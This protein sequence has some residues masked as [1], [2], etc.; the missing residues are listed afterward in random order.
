M[1]SPS[2]RQ[3]KLQLITAQ[4]KKIE[5]DTKWLAENLSSWSSQ[6][7]QSIRAKTNERTKSVESDLPKL[8]QKA[9][10]SN[11]DKRTYGK[12]MAEKVHLA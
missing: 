3:T 5:E 9:S 10:E 2:P 12:A 8:V 4:V 6:E 7:S 1:T 11:P